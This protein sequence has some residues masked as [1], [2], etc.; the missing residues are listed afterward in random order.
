M[1]PILSAIWDFVNS[2]FGAAVLGAIAGA[3]VGGLGTALTARWVYKS[4]EKRRQETQARELR[5]TL[6]VNLLK[7]IGDLRELR[8]APE[9]NQYRAGEVESAAS[10]SLALFSAHLDL[11][12]EWGMKEWI[13]RVYDGINEFE[14]PWLQHHIYQGYVAEQ[15]LGWSV[16][17]P[18]LPVEWFEELC[19]VAPTAFVP[20]DLV[21]RPFSR[22]A[23][24][25][26]RERLR[27]NPASES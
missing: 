17:D 2:S 14:E 25:R 15:L 22:D 20:T 8:T 9:R 12:R 13:I 7:A 24:R 4:E 27:S 18:D 5:R 16:G 19:E 21:P 26:R 23:V 11:P 10:S 1:G 6:T 3:V